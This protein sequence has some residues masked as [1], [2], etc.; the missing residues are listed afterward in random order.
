MEVCV[1]VYQRMFLIA[2]IV[3]C[4]HVNVTACTK[5]DGVTAKDKDVA[6][7]ICAVFATEMYLREVRV[8]KSVMDVDITLGFYRYLCTD[9]VGGE[10]FLRDLHKM[11]LGKSGEPVGTVWLYV[12]GDKVAEADSKLFGGVQVRLKL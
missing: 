8:N 6:K 11:L 3:L 7:S 2:A 1:T 12:D 9:E 5:F 4:F 10:K